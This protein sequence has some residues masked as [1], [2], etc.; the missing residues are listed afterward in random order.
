LPLLIDPESFSLLLADELVSPLNIPPNLFPQLVFLVPPPVV[1]TE[2]SAIR[3]LALLLVELKLRIRRCG[4]TGISL[5]VETFFGLAC[6]MT[7]SGPKIT[8]DF[9]ILT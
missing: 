3:G 4:V 6:A 1:D 9:F 7:P 8:A 5:G 2:N